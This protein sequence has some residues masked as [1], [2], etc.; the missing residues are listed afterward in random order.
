[1]DFNDLSSR[2]QKILSA[3][4][5]RYIT[6]AEPVSSRDI[7]EKDNIDYSSAT[8]RSELKT[9]EE[10][11]YLVKPHVSAGR[12]PSPKAYRL[13]VEKLMQSNPL[14]ADEIKKLKS[15][16]EKKHYEVSSIIKDTAKIISDVTNYTSV[17]V[18]NDVKEIIVKDIKLVDLS[19]NLALVIIMTDSGIISNKTINI[20]NDIESNYFKMANDLVNKIFAGKTVNE[21]N[22][23]NI[24]L[25]RELED[26]KTIFENIIEI[27]IDYSNNPNNEIY[28]EGESKILNYPEYQN[29]NNAKQLMTLIESKDKLKEIIEDDND[30]EVQLKIGKDD[31]GLDNTAIVTAKY[32]ING[33]EV[34][35][36]GVIGP[37][38]MNYNKVLSVLNYITNSL[39]SFNK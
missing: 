37:E 14:S 34:G 18:L 1:M 39:N 24:D 27:L 26:F 12:L 31:N 16:F 32:M 2:K 17:V 30:I 6:S 21:I 36:A 28:L 25:N 4:I 35:H 29:I 19:S 5:E 38:R 9:L 15:H 23:Y 20:N 10:M 13:Y 22:N 11:G 8:V 3:L 7:V 33:K